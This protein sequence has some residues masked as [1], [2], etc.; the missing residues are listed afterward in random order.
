LDSKILNKIA[1]SHTPQDVK[2]LEKLG[3]KNYVEEQLNPDDT[4]DTPSVLQRLSALKIHIEYNDKGKKVNEERLIQHLNKSQTDLWRELYK[5][6]ISFREKIQPAVEVG[7]STWVRAVYSRW[8]VREIMVLFWHNH[9]NVNVAKDERIGL[10]FPVYDK[11][12]IR[13]H[14]LGNFRAFLE[15]VAKSPAMQYYLNNVSSQASPANENYARELFELHTLGREAYMN[16][17]YNRWREV[18][19]ATEGKPTGYIDEDVYE[20]A[21]AFTGWTIADGTDNGK[22]SKFPNTGAAHYYEGWHDNYQKRVLGVE[23]PPNQPPMADGKQVLDLVAFH[24]ATARHICKK[25]CQRFIS[26]APSEGVIQKAVEVFIKNQKAPDQI[27]Q[28]VRTILLSDECQNSVGQKTKTPFELVASFIRTTE[29]DFT[30]TDGFFWLMN[31]TGYTLFEWQ[32]PTGHPDKATYWLNPNM[33]LNRWNILNVL[34][35]DWQKTIK[36]DVAK[37]IPNASTLTVAQI[38]D[39]LIKKMLNT[40]G[41]GNPAK[42]GEGSKSGEGLIKLRNTIANFVADGASIEEP[43]WGDTKSLDKKIIQ[44]VALIGMSPEFQVR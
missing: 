30:P 6:N 13:R 26:D 44:A 3:Y 29:A 37:I 43:F 35:S 28:V 27:K 40:E 18:P 14:A 10:T 31:Q 11:D 38:S 20:A 16:N 33:M 32:T 24:P 8:Q 12:V 2:Q 39:L 7:V 34:T 23:L 15:D 17:L 41:V 21:R 19:G 22:G 9:F 25:L 42:S 5:E 4:K 1:Y 36:W